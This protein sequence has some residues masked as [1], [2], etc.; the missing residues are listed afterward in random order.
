MGALGL[1][2]PDSPT[3]TID[4]IN[5][6]IANLR[7]RLDSQGVNTA[8]PEPEESLLS[9]SLRVL[10]VPGA[11]VR[12]LIKAGID[13]DYN[14]T[15]IEPY[16]NPVGGIDLLD[17]LGLAPEATGT[18]GNKAARFGLGLATDLVT[19]PL[20]FV[21]GGVTGPLK[22]LRA[23]VIGKS[24]AQLTK[25]GLAQPLLRGVGA[26]LR[27][28]GALGAVLGD[29]G[30]IAARKAATKASQ[31]APNTS[32]A[33]AEVQEI[34]AKAKSLKA[35]RALTRSEQLGLEWGSGLRENPMTRGAISAVSKN[36]FADPAYVALRNRLADGVSKKQ[37]AALGEWD[38]IVKG[39]TP[40]QQRLFVDLVEDGGTRAKYGLDKFPSV[41]GREGASPVTP[42]ALD[43]AAPS[44]MN[45]GVVPT[46]PS[47]RKP[48]GTL[49][50]FDKRG[51][52]LPAVDDAERLTSTDKFV[53]EIARTS[54]LVPTGLKNSPLALRS[55]TE[56][57]LMQELVFQLDHAYR[58]NPDGLSYVALE[59]VRRGEWASASQLLPLGWKRVYDDIVKRGVHP[60]LPR[61]GESDDVARAS[62][63]QTAAKKISSVPDRDSR[64]LMGFWV[65]KT[66]A[67]AVP[68]EAIPGRTVGVAQ[69]T[70]AVLPSGRKPGSPITETSGYGVGNDIRDKLPE[71]LTA[72]GHWNVKID[73]KNVIASTGL[74]V[75]PEALRNH[76]ST[77]LMQ[78]FAAQIQRRNA[79]TLRDTVYEM[80]RRGVW[81]DGIRRMPLTIQDAYRQLVQRGIHP[82][83]PPLGAS[84]ETAREFL[85]QRADDLLGPTSDDP[86]RVLDLLRV[87]TTLRDAVP[88]GPGETVLS[89]APRQVS[90]EAGRLTED[91][92]RAQQVGNTLQNPER[93]P[94][95]FEGRANLFERDAVQELPDNVRQAYEHVRSALDQYGNEKVRRGLLGAMI[96]N[97]FPHKLVPEEGVGISASG[98]KLRQDS[99]KLREIRQPLKDI[100]GKPGMPE[101]EH[102]G[103]RPF[104]KEVVESIRSIDTFDFMD[105][106]VGQFGIK[107]DDMAK[108]HGFLPSS[109]LDEVQGGYKLVDF[110]SFFIGGKQR[111]VAQQTFSKLGKVYLP[112]EIA[113]DISRI[114]A[115]Y[116]TDEGVKTFTKLWDGATN[117]WKPLVT[118]LNLPFHVNNLFGNMWNSFLGG[119]ENPVRLKD[120]YDILAGRARQLKA[121][122]YTVNLTDLRSLADKHGVIKGGFFENEIGQDV[123]SL[124][125]DGLPPQSEGN[126]A[127]A[128]QAVSGGFN[129]AQGYGRKLGSFIEG[130]NRSALFTDQMVKRIASATGEL[131]PELMDDMA[132]Q[133]AQHVNKYLFDYAH[134]LSRFE[135]DIVRRVAPFYAWTKFNIPLQVAELVNQPGKF[136]AY[137]KFKDNLASVNPM[138]DDTPP[139][140]REALPTGIGTADGGQ[141]FV[142]PRLPLQD[143]SRLDL[144]MGDK[145]PGRELLG[146]LNPLIKTPVE[147]LA[148]ERGFNF[149]KGRPIAD[150]AGQ[151]TEILPGLRVSKKAAHV[152]DSMT[153]SVGR[154]GTNVPEL[155]SADADSVAKL[156]GLRFFFPGIYT[157][158]PQREQTNSAYR[159]AQRLQDLIRKFEDETGKQVPTKRQLALGL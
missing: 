17:Q 140:L 1:A 9:K 58:G 74:K 95:D 85:R 130:L 31:L 87:N 27:N 113:D 39:M 6:D 152:Y 16:D 88:L 43:S 131:T 15:D 137:H 46:L 30:V 134:G 115:A 5:S 135:N 62:L 98:A 157:Y 109:K 71:G 21:A 24:V 133:S 125:R 117:F 61:L 102:E 2:Q 73:G 8:Q 55:Y 108:R 63:Q 10:N 127:K 139:W 13:P 142:N 60:L 11:T 79:K 150:Y 26:G 153:G 80:V 119:L 78:E 144:G 103:V 149:Y 19:D 33:M 122:S 53:L 116:N 82:L 90:T 67:D 138:S 65:D 114:H 4:R 121:G 118:T 86:K 22:L 124:V 148:G 96:Q 23:P 94:V 69:V 151:T 126:I 141:V 128:Y 3:A 100:V 75:T 37:R 92:L 25:Q 66:L 29:E 132:R 54:D 18:F 136:L 146:M 12:G 158:N 68:L 156:R 83:L 34:I 147:Y 56:P 76:T 14:V 50:A 107:Y 155:L 48:G 38:K 159:E 20:S 89:S 36:A 51:I 101:F 145:N 99:A 52:G 7:T 28:T 120:G 104:A 40:E 91:N 72:D 106:V 129:K 81:E 47:G 42:S 93:V 105:D 112:T 97:Y 154:L 44:S 110:D 77:Q 84:D 70:D 57:Q 49:P 32:Q 123:M 35:P 143:I 64:T 111:P 59:L 41:L 45:A